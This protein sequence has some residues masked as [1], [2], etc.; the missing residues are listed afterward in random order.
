MRNLRPILKVAIICTGAAFPFVAVQADEGP[1]RECTKIEDRIGRQTCKLEALLKGCVPTTA[2]S[3]KGPGLVVFT[4]QLDTESEDE[5]LC[6][7]SRGV[8]PTR[9]RNF[10]S[11]RGQAAGIVPSPSNV[12][13]SMQTGEASPIDE[14]IVR[15]GRTVFYISAP[16]SDYGCPSS[17]HLGHLILFP[18]GGSGSSMIDVMPLVVDGSSVGFGSSVS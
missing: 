3:H 10:H 6:L 16:N 17:K 13:F 11:S 7:S 12:V 18:M 8:T 15:V 2:V 1:T 4:M 9:V 5:L 14:L